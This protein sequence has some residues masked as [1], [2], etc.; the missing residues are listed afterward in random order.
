MKR[1]FDIVLALFGLLFFSPIF[2]ISSLLI[3]CEDFNSP[4]YISKRVG[5]DFK[6]FHFIKLR[7]MLINADKSGI[8]STSDNDIR[9]TKIGKFIR[10][11]KLDELPQLWNVL[12]GDMSFVGP[13]PNVESEVKLYTMKEKKLLRVK[14]GITDFASIIFSDEGSILKNHKNPDLGY[15]Q[16]IRP[17]KNALALFYL[18]RNNILIDFYIILLTVL[19]IFNKK[20]SLYQI[21]ILLQRLNAPKDLVLLA[22]RKEKLIPKPPPGSKEIVNSI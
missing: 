19:A 3:F 2:I 16:L 13:R 5:K 15:H 14:P 21:K 17:G 18:K 11:F 6:S 4:F 1:I 8:N 22:S 9:I 20:K 10:K 7:S 12:I